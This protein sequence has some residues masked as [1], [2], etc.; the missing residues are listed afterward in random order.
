[1]ASVRSTGAQPEIASMYQRLLWGIVSCGLTAAFAYEALTSNFRSEQL[2]AARSGLVLDARTR[3]PLADAYV[4]TRWLQQDTPAWGLGEVHGQCL[5][6][7]I[8]RTDAQ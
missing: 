6:R 5:H 1:N 4:V 7:V 3:K 2:Q 8:V